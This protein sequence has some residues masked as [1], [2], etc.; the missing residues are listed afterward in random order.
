MTST[1]T[2]NSTYQFLPDL[3]PD[4]YESL[5][6]SI[7]KRGVDVHIFVDQDG[8]VVDGFHRDR[9]CSELGIYCP[10]KVCQFENEAQKFELALRLNCRRRQLNRSQ[11]RDLISA[12]MKRDPQIADNH[13]AALIGGI[14]KNTVADIRRNLE[15]TCQIDKF[16]K[17][18]G[19]DGKDRP[20]KYKRIIANTQK[21]TEK[22]LIDIAN[23]PETCNGKTIDSITAARRARRNNKTER[24]TETV[25]PPTN[26]DDIQIHHCRFQDLETVADIEP[27]SVNLILTDIP[28]DGDFLPQVSELAEMANR[29]LV[30]GGVLAV[31]S[32]QFYLDEV[33]RQLRE[34][35]NWAWLG[36]AVW[37]GD[38][39]MIHQRQCANQSKPMLVFN[40]GEWKERKRWGDLSRVESKE[41]QW[42]PMQQPVEDVEHWL[43]SFSKAGDLV[44]D[45]CGGSFTTAVACYR[46]GDRRFIGCDWDE[47][48]VLGGRQ[49]MAEE[50]AA[51]SEGPTN[52][53]PI[54]CEGTERGNHVSDH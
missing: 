32:G 2:N 43:R 8:E 37:N 20:Q 15:A 19:K 3:F 6:E 26:I 18:R 53:A 29:I 35:L 36:T 47:S 40:K 52:V 51:G 39:N 22:A 41:K 13:L 11:K 5:K 49:R 10:R 4:E 48:Y 1:D 54:D 27:E 30:D 42:H 44:V 23:L 45:V 24:R 17:L 16:E 38:A 25:T 14:S 34:H 12:Y 50:R 33:I 46:S 28:Y 21:E 31:L 7:A 9:A